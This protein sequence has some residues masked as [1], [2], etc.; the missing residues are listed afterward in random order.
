VSAGRGLEKDS[1]VSIQLNHIIIPAKEK[2]TSAKFLAAILGLEPGPQWGPFVPIRT[3]NGVT[4]D[5]VDAGHFEPY[6]CAF[7]VSDV[8]FDAALAHLRDQRLVFYAD[9][10]RKQPGEINHLYGGRGVYFDDPN[11]H[12]LELITQPYGTAP[13]M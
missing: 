2:W 7:L 8:E 5:F 11:G 1:N 4:I 12:L 9:F 13:E 10:S 6:H 3:S